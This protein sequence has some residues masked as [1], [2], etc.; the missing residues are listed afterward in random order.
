MLAASQVELSSIGITLCLLLLLLLLKYQLTQTIKQFCGEETFF[1]ATHASK[2]LDDA[3]AVRFIP[4]ED[5]EKHLVLQLKRLAW[6]NWFSVFS[7]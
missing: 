2:V 3:I 7:F 1:D 5:V 4:L 6:L